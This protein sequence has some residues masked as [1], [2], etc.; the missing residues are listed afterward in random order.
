M[1]RATAE[2]EDVGRLKKGDWI[3]R[4]NEN[5]RVDAPAQV[6][7]IKPSTKRWSVVWLAPSGEV[8]RELERLT[9]L[10]YDGVIDYD[11]FQAARKRLLDQRAPS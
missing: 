3:L 10:R 4:V 9:E 1:P 7:E 5:G 6:V 2:A 11:E 8:A